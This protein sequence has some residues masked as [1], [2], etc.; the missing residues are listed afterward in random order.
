M[1]DSYYPSPARTRQEEPGLTSP[2]VGSIA[3]AVCFTIA[4]FLFR[5][6]SGWRFFFMALGGIALFWALW[7]W[8]DWML[9]RSGAHVQRLREFYYG[10]QLEAMRLLDRMDPRKLDIL[11]AGGILTLKP[12]PKLV[13]GHIHWLIKTDRMDIPL[14]WLYEYLELCEETFP[15][16]PALHGLND[17]TERA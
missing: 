4:L 1:D 7:Y 2:I 11:E 12:G 14:P 3:A 6:G 17:N 15:K 5:P 16:F 13:D 8:L 10:P 9:W